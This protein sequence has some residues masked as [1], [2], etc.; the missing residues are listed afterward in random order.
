MDSNVAGILA[1]GNR[2][3]TVEGISNFNIIDFVLSRFDVRPKSNNCVHWY[4]GKFVVLISL[5]CEVNCFSAEKAQQIIWHWW[6][7]HPGSHITQRRKHHLQRV[8]AL[9]PTQLPMIHSFQSYLS[10]LK[11]ALLLNILN[12]LIPIYY[13]IESWKNCFRSSR[14]QAIGHQHQPNYTTTSL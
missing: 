8:T 13:S 7:L 9:L 10:K 1:E 4:F 2:Q 11:S 5:Q 14:L 12:M 6:R 3:R